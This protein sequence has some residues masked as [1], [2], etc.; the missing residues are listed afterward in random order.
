M[1]LAIQYARTENIPYLG[2]CLGSQ[3]MAIE[4][5]RNVLNYSDAT[6]EEFD[7]EYIS[8]HHIVHIMEDQKNISEKGGTM[9]LGIYDCV[10][11][12]GSKVEELYK[13][14]VIVHSEGSPLGGRNEAIHQTQDMD[15]HAS[16]AMTTERH[17]HRYEFN[18][19][20]RSEFEK[21]GFIISGTSPDG[22]LVEMVELNNH[23]FMIATQAHPEF[24]SRPTR[25][26]PLMMGFV[27]ACI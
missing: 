6:S 14:G 8:K 22:S 19:L 16:L 15:R 25:P 4:F 21:N 12:E 23:P 17:R 10:L 2:I 9:R 26:H 11:K 5:A 7:P 13:K 27:G 24:K 1:I 20:Y 18:N 3:L